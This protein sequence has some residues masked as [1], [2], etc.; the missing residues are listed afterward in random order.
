[1]VLEVAVA[2]FAVILFGVTYWMFWAGMA[3]STGVLRLRRCHTCGH[4]VPTARGEVSICPYCRHQR[5]SRHLA[6]HRLRH[7]FPGEW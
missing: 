3:G 6:H 4:L 1:M 2:V 7:Y 5:I